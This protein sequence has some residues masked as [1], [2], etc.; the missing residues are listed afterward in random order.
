MAPEMAESS[1]RLKVP[2]ASGVATLKKRA[3]RAVA[4]AESN[5][6]AGCGLATRPSTSNTGFSSGS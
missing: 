1:A 4:E 3:M 6:L 2:K 5:R